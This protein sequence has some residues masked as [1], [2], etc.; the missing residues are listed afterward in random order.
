VVVERHARAAGET[1]YSIG[2]RTSGAFNA[3][4]SFSKLPLRLVTMLGFTAAA[5]SLLGA[6]YVIFGS[7]FAHD[8]VPGWVSLMTVVLLVSGVQLLTLG[9]VGEYVGK[10]YDEVRNRPKFIVADRWGPPKEGSEP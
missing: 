3:I 7:A 5:C 10:V 6:L 4:T 2:V 9:I 1:K 8:V